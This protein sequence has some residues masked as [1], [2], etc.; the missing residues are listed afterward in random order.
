MACR[1]RLVRLGDNQ[2]SGQ[3]VGEAQP[4]QR[5]PRVGFGEREGSV[6]LFVANVRTT[7]RMNG[8]TPL[9]RE[10]IFQ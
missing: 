10:D 2:P 9:V 3:R 7:P 1:A 8:N 4:G 6:R 5:D